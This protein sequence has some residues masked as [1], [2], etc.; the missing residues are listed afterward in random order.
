MQRQNLELKRPARVYLISTV[1]GGMISIPQVALF[2]VILLRASYTWMLVN[3][4]LQIISVIVALYIVNRKCN[5]AYKLAWCVCIL[6]LPLLGGAFYIVARSRQ[7]Y[8]SLRRKHDRVL[9]DIL[10][11]MNKEVDTSVAYRADMVKASQQTT[12][13][14]STTSPPPSAEGGLVQPTSCNDSPL[15]WKGVPVRAGVVPSRLT[16][17]L[18]RCGFPTHVESTPTFFPTGESMYEDLLDKLRRA[19]RFIFLEF[20]IIRTG[21]MWDGVRTILEQKAAE[22]VDVRLIYDGFGS[23]KTLPHK[24]HKELRKMGIKT[25]VFRPFVPVVTTI[26]NNRNH[27]KIV[28]IDGEWAYTGGINLSDEYINQYDRCGH[29]K[30]A[31]IRVEGNSVTSF[32]RMFLEMWYMDAPYDADMRKFFVANRESSVGALLG[33]PAG[34]ASASPTEP[35]PSHVTPYSYS[36]LDREEVA[37]NVYLEMIFAARRYLYIATPYLIPGSEILAALKLAAASGVDVR[38]ITP[39]IG[40]KGYMQVA[41]RSNYLELVAAGVRVYEYNPGFIHSKYF[42]IDDSCATVGTV[43][44]DYRSL[45][46]NYECGVVVE[47]SDFAAEIK[48]DFV[49]TL[50]QCTEITPDMARS[51]GWLH[52][53]AVGV[54]R[55]FEPML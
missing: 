31:G 47:C 42:V 55:L 7:K 27:R 9:R 11:E 21:I 8:K 38:M 48:N 52:R 17:Y 30:D 41:T 22:D 24:Y 53:M 50:E 18:A 54:L 28:I 12:Q 40:D 49:T 32:T 6:I 13:P 4:A 29:W 3:F 16:T 23:M 39:R 10:T 51:K 1:I 35:P 19:E 15:P 45:F 36:P 34:R 43:N 44:L 37:K 20:F 46:L 14:P 2:A 26:Q 25:Q 5:T 33:A